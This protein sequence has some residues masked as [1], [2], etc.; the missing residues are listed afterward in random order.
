MSLFVLYISLSD[1]FVPPIGSSFIYN[2]MPLV[3]RERKYSTHLVGAIGTLV[4]QF[5]PYDTLVKYL[6][7]V[8]ETHNQS[9]PILYTTHLNVSSPYNQV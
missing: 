1:L 6:R 9:H 3:M 5:V 4:R 7:R 2:C 8:N